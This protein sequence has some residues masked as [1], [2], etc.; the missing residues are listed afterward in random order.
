MR[1]TPWLTG[2]VAAIT[3]VGLVVQE[4]VPGTLTALQRSPAALH[5][6]LWRWITPLVVQD[7][8]LAGAAI[9]MFGLLLVGTAAEQVVRQSGLDHGVRRGR[10]GRSGLRARLAAGRR[11]QLGGGLRA[12]GAARRH[13]GPWARRADAAAGVRRVPCGAVRWPVP[14]GGRWR[15]WAASSRCWRTVRPG[16]SAGR[17]TPSWPSAQA[18]RS[19]SCWPR[20]C[21]VAPW[22][23]PS[24]SLQPHPSQTGSS[25]TRTREQLPE[26][27]SSAA[28]VS[29]DRHPLTSRPVRRRRRSDAD[30]SCQSRICSDSPRRG[31]TTR[32][33]H[34]PRRP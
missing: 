3:L 26:S 6:E 27:R 33:T 13:A 14:C 1:R 19:S 21:T 9:N 11:G 10:V 12:G 18:A 29:P 16:T 4:T 31:S 25:S 22:E 15:S 5:G 30:G 24:W 7:G 2:L 28:T 8:W 20:T 17:R 23:W 34:R 32:R